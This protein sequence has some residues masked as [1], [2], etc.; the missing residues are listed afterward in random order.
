[1][2]G[3]DHAI[4]LVLPSGVYHYKFLVDGEWRYIPDAPSFTDTVGQTVNLLDVTVRLCYGSYAFAIMLFLEVGQLA[5]FPRYKFCPPSVLFQDYVPENPENTKEFDGPPSPDT[6]YGRSLLVDE[7]FAKDPPALPPQLHL[8]VLCPEASVES[9]PKP[10]HVV[11]NHLFTEKG[12][13]AQS[14]VAFG[15]THRFQSKY[16]TIVLYKPMRRQ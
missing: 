13:V 11:L 2:S 3:K 5:I 9:S 16:V 6:S 10:Q 7:D 14:L 4:L 12:W 15:M 1:M 8:T